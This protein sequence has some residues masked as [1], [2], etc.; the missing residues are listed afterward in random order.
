MRNMVNKSQKLMEN[1][2]IVVE[3]R[4]NGKEVNMQEAASI[5]K[6]KVMRS[7]NIEKGFNK[8]LKVLKY[9][10]YFQELP[11]CSIKIP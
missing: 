10:E 6:K 3:A 8:V 5:R 4:Q 9:W 1:A 11:K 2:R 7:R